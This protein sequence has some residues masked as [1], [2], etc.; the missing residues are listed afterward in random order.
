MLSRRRFLTASGAIIGGLGSGLTPLRA[1]ENTVP[2]P[3]NAPDKPGRIILLVS[4]GMSAGTFALT[5]IF[6]QRTREKPLVWKDLM[7][8]NGVVNACMNTR[9]ANA[10]VTDS[11]AAASSWGCGVRVPNGALNVRSDGR[12]LVPLYDL[13]RDQDWATALVTTAEITHA[14]PAGMAVASESRHAAEDIAVQYLDRRVHLLYGGGAVF[15]DPS[16]RMDRRDLFADFQKAGYSLIRNRSELLASTQSGP[17]LAVF[18]DSHLPYTLDEIQNPS[19]PTAPTLAEMTS[20]ALLAL[21]GKEHFFLQVEAARVDHAAHNSDIA[22]VI[23]DQL[24]F[25]DAVQVCLDFQTRFPDTLVVITTD[26]GNS[27]PGLNN[28]AL[29]NGSTPFVE[30]VGKTRQS[31]PKIL[32][33]IQKDAETRQVGLSTFHLVNPDQLASVLLD[34]TGF[35]PHRAQTEQL[36]SAFAGNS[37]ALYGQMTKPVTQL[38]QWLANHTGVGWTGNTHT[39]DYVMLSAVGP[40]SERFNG[41]LENTDLFNHFTDLAG[42]DFRN[43]ALPE[44]AADLHNNPPHA[45]ERVEEYV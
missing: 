4:D 14:T 34:A 18:S 40:G 21:E 9:S 44:I 43:P 33:A 5:D 13:L 11:A 42:I 7:K 30:A 26:H 24:A 19:G 37:N 2:S 41:W 10:L 27:N 17:Q 29:K 15:F 25:D 6:S 32:S 35:S 39:S 31:F 22:A 8:K 16:R 36:L 3:A 38:G 23:H 12:E 28:T 45:Q 1:A 20:S